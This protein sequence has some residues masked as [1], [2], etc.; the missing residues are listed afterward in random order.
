VPR[1][2]RGLTAIIA[3]ATFIVVGCSDDDAASPASTS[4]APA[5]AVGP[6]D[7]SGTPSP[8]PSTSTGVPATSVVGTAGADTTVAVA[9]GAPIDIATGLDVP[10]TVAF[11]GETALVSERGTGNILELL[12]DGTTRAIGTVGGVLAVNESGL[13]GLAV[14]T[15]QRLYAYSTAADQNR[16]QRFTVDGA[17]GSYTLGEPTTIIDGIPTAN[18]HD[19]GRL[20]FGPDGMLYVTVGDTGR[21]DEAQDVESLAGKILRITPDGGIPDDNPFAGSP[22][23][24][25]GHR[26]PQGVGWADDGTMFAAE[27]GQN[28]WDELNIIQPGANYGWPIAEGITGGEFTDPVQQWATDDASPSGLAVVDGTVYIANLRGE[29]LRAIP[30]ADPATSREYFTGEYGRLRA[31]TLAPDGTLWIITNNTDGRGQPQADDDRIISVPLADV[32]S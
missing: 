22:V 10:W 26:N 31:V 13:L 3:A 1:R 9:A 17:P 30:V 6:T 29:R 21:S 14:D 25:M 23:Y 4:P 2:L 11:L 32:P 18:F 20:A 12:P 19:G 15:E 27:F 5:T 7:A 24:S 16:V 8:S 28:T